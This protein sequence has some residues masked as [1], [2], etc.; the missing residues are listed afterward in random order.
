MLKIA[1]FSPMPPSKSGIADYSAAL[2]DALRGRAEV[3]V[4]T[5][6]PSSL[7]P[8]RYDSIV[9]QMGNNPFHSFVYDA[10]MRY[11]GTVV[12]H[13]ANLHHLIADVTIRRGDWDAYL[14]ECEFDGGA[15]ALD[16]A[17][18]VRSLEIGP[19]YDGLPMIKR[20]LSVSKAAIAHSNYVAGYIRRTGFTGPVGVIPHGSWVSD[21]ASGPEYRARLGLPLDTPL[22]GIFGFLKP[23]KRVAESLRAFRRLLQLRPDVRLLLVGE[24]HPEL[25]LSAM[26]RAQGLELAVRHIDFAPID[27]FNG[28]LAACDIV[29]NLRHPTVGETS[30]TLQRALGLG[31]PVIVSN[32]GAFA[33]YPDSATLKVDIGPHEEAEIFEY[34]NL[35]VSRPDLAR[36]MGANAK[37]WVERECSWDTVASRYCRFLAGDPEPERQPEPVPVPISPEEHRAADQAP[38][39]AISSND[40][41][42]WTDPQPGARDYVEGHLSRFERTLEITPQGGPEDSVLEMGA[43]M[44]ITAAL[45]H[46]RG[47][48]RVRGCYFGPAGKV[49]EKQV[50]AADGRTFACS[51]DL[52]DA[53]K[54]IF[55][56]RDGE[57]ATVLC[58]EL[59]EHLP[60]DPMH[61]MAEIHRVLRPGGHLVITTPNV[62]SLR[63]IAAILSGYHP[64]FYPAYLKP[65]ALAA[66]D[67]RHNREYTPREIHLLLH[68]AGFE[69]THLSTGPFREEPKPEL[70]WVEAL[71]DRYKQDTALRGDGIYAVGRKST[72]VRERYP[73][74]LYS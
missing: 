60:S 4:F 48:G 30:G 8:S 32:V 45:H 52:F 1:F 26:I 46:R 10:A 16:F 9:Y 15:P 7:D 24:C 21:S 65:E 25:P 2:L 37:A 72:A 50:E 28:Y 44:H 70:L 43:Y 23:Y 35:L 19:D 71:L 58:C 39:Y 20:L 42:V 59:L 29:L 49:E 61:M 62:A 66:G 69:V 67:S 11:P 56:Y 27:D 17:R 55:P 34:L 6:M 54:D 40:I 68:Y 51:I 38:L 3:D 64:G 74:W 22:I 41:T 57:F 13:E 18:R 47:Y 31:K 36:S 33:E 63:A 53:E 12:L 5:S 14:R 73:A